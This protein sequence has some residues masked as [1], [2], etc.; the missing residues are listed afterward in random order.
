M[1]ATQLPPLAED[2][3]VR[4]D[5]AAAGL[6]RQD[7]EELVSELRSHL[8]SALPADATD[9][10][11]LN[12]LDGVGTPE[13]IVAAAASETSATPGEMPPEPR[14]TSPWGAVEVLAVLSLTVGTFVLPIVGPVLGLVLVW[15]S[16]QWTRREK[17]VATILSVLPVIA[18]ILAALS[19]VVVR[20]DSSIEQDP[21]PSQAPQVEE[22]S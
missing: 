19:L 11:V 13:A 3:L 6:P 22:G 9:A 4:L 14:R 2:Y 17:T 7:R 10:D 16:V 8:E 18:L 12:V 15:V 1:R 21:V 20:E 5:H